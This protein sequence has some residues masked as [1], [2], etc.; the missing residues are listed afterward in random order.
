MQQVIPMEMMSQQRPRLMVS[1]LLDPLLWGFLRSYVL[2]E[3][4]LQKNSSSSSSSSSAKASE[5]DPSNSNGLSS[6][7]TSDSGYS[8][9]KSLFGKNSNNDNGQSKHSMYYSSLDQTQYGLERFESASEILMILDLFAEICHLVQ[10]TPSPG[11]LVRFDSLFQRFTSQEDEIQESLSSQLFHLCKSYKYS[12]KECGYHITERRK[13]QSQLSIDDPIEEST[14]LNEAKKK[15][16]QKKKKRKKENSVM[17]YNFEDYSNTEDS[18]EFTQQQQGE[19]HQPETFGGDLFKRFFGGGDLNNNNTHDTNKRS[20]DTPQSTTYSSKYGSSMG[21]LSMGMI[22]EEGGGVDDGGTVG[23]GDLENR[24]LD[25]KGNRRKHGFKPSWGYRGKPPP[26]SFISILLRMQLRENYLHDEIR[27]MVQ[28]LGED[29]QQGLID[30]Y[31]PDLPATMN[32]M[33]ENYDLKKNHEFKESD[34]EAPKFSK[35]PISYLKSLSQSIKMSPIEEDEES[36]FS[37]PHSKGMRRRK[38]DETKIKKSGI[39]KQK[40]SELTT[41]IL[42]DI[43]MGQKATKFS[44]NAFDR[45]KSRKETKKSMK[46]YLRG[47]VDFW[48]AVVSEILFALMQHQEI[49]LAFASSLS[50]DDYIRISQPPLTEWKADGFYGS[51]N[52]FHSL[53]EDDDSDVDEKKRDSD[54]L[55]GDPSQSYSSSYQ[56]DE[57]YKKSRRRAER[58]RRN[59]RS[60]SMSSDSKGDEDDD[61]KSNS[62]TIETTPL[63]RPN[64]SSKRVKRKKKTKGGFY[65]HNE[66]ADFDSS[67]S[68]GGKWNF[69]FMEEQLTMVDVMIDGSLAWQRLHLIENLVN[70][71]I[72]PILRPSWIDIEKMF[73]AADLR[74]HHNPKMNVRY[75]SSGTVFLR[76]QSSHSNKKSL[77]EGVVN[78]DELPL[79]RLQSTS[80]F[81]GEDPTML[82]EEEEDIIHDEWNAQFMR[83]HKKR[84]RSRQRAKDRISSSTQRDGG[85]L[86]KMKLPSPQH[87]TLAIGEQSRHFRHLD[88]VLRDSLGF[89]FFRRFCKLHYQEENL[90]FWLEV[91]RLKGGMGPSNELASLSKLPTIW[92]GT[93]LSH[94]HIIV[95]SFVRNGSKFELNISGDLREKIIVMLPPLLPKGM[96][97]DRSDNSPLAIGLPHHKRGL[98]T[99]T[100]GNRSTRY[101]SSSQKEEEEGKVPPSSRMSEGYNFDFNQGISSSEDEYDIEEDY[102]DDENGSNMLT[103]QNKAG[104]VKGSGRKGGTLKPNYFSRKDSTRDEVI[105]NIFNPAQTQVQ[106]LMEGNLWMKFKQTNWYKEL[107][108]RNGIRIQRFYGP[109][110]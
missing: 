25:Q 99:N 86:Y 39:F 92:D 85:N 31:S 67:N 48:E 8:F 20:L 60:N 24:H 53:D 32:E 93:L 63:A 14:A 66:E 68:Y 64:R 22:R 83:E 105:I 34:E 26:I 17:S 107:K 65:D 47:G 109:I 9:L 81:G 11:R 50:F 3:E 100:P 94:A 54:G 7:A 72:P 49:L 12:L 75:S 73:N 10:L 101:Q 33:I 4:A 104:R 98:S 90:I 80:S 43:I 59:S 97:R 6:S 74:T 46:E 103:I 18:F 37:S 21:N 78:D 70:K 91:E 79:L 16:K 56:D 96:S 2:R 42:W 106:I 87:P 44:P 30:P 23:G 57:I 69:N 77:F 13:L 29:I 110:G 52:L 45:P 36:V 51:K 35:N 5:N 58:K 62:P 27:D 38:G 61:D 1:M 88:E 84:L 76:Q 95:N 28:Q 108:K 41:P 55:P 102:D 15:T 19:R 71:A 82:L 89:A 40:K